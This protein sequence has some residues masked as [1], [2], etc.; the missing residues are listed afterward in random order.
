V[1]LPEPRYVVT[2]I[3]GYEITEPPAS[4]PGVSFTVIDRHVCHRVMQTFRSEDYKRDDGRHT[5]NAMRIA[6]ARA[7]AHRKCE[8]LNGELPGT[9]IVTPRARFRPTCPKCGRIQSGHLL[10]CA[11]AGCGA[12]LTKQTRR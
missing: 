11:F 2:E 7:N 1:T 3:E 5:G 9:E 4:T 12:D 10:V 6:T 8:R